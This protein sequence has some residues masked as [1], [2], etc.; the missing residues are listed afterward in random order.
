MIKF[1]SAK[2]IWSKYFWFFSSN[3]LI[4]RPIRKVNVFQLCQLEHNG[5]NTKRFKQKTSH[6]LFFN[7]IPTAR[8]SQG[9]QNISSGLCYHGKTLMLQKSYTRFNIWHFRAGEV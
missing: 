9:L 1:L 6:L 2:L 3:Q 8:V 5:D 7:E 4:S